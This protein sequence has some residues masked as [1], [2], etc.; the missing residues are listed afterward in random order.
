M[1]MVTTLDFE[2]SRLQENCSGRVVYLLFTK[3]CTNSIHPAV[4][5]CLFYAGLWRN[6]VI[7][8]DIGWVAGYSL[9]RSPVHIKTNYQT[10]SFSYRQEY[11][12]GP[13][14]VV[15][16]VLDFGPQAEFLATWNAAIYAKYS[17]LWISKWIL[18]YQVQQGNKYT[19]TEQ[20]HP[21]KLIWGL[22]EYNHEKPPKIRLQSCD[23]QSRSL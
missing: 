7:L 6:V 13:V 12:F 4:I 20:F 18:N 10:R 2:W 1:W 3:Y 17:I 5:Y 9:D 15:R 14:I 21:A 22:Y 16:T 11:L 19:K 8:V 23:S